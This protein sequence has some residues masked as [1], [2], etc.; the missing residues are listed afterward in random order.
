MASPSTR[1]VL[2]RHYL[3]GC[4]GG[5]KSLYKAGILHKDISINNLMI[6]EDDD[7]PSWPSFLIDLDLVIR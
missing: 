5:H 6:N 7:N 4:I 1:R 3:P 2:G